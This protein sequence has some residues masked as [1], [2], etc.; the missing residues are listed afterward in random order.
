MDSA[1]AMDIY[2][3]THGSR[4]SIYIGLLKNASALYFHSRGSQGELEEI[5]RKKEE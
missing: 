5:C 4:F 2:A 1:C 3:E